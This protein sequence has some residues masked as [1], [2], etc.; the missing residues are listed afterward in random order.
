MMMMM[1]GRGLSFCN[2]TRPKTGSAPSCNCLHVGYC[3]RLEG[4]A[5]SHHATVPLPVAAPVQPLSAPP[6]TIWLV[7]A[8]TRDGGV[9]EGLKPSRITRTLVCIL[10][11]KNST[12]KTCF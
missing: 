6:R 2:L 4:L 3:V 9:D 1:G 10:K 11:V 12:N 8:S 7:S 5:T